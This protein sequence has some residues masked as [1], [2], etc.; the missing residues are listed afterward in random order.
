MRFFKNFSRYVLSVSLCMGIILSFSAGN[1]YAANDTVDSI[2]SSLLTVSVRTEK[3]YTDLPCTTVDTPEGEKKFYQFSLEGQTYTMKGTL[4]DGE[5]MVEGENQESAEFGLYGV[6][7]INNDSPAFNYKGSE[8]LS[9]NTKNMSGNIIG[10]GDDGG[11]AIFSAGALSFT[12]NGRLYV[13]GIRSDNTIIV[14]DGVIICNGEL[15]AKDGVFLI[16]GTV[17]AYGGDIQ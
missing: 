9:F 8:E 1:L 3:G 2:R 17:L 12:G 11:P 5:I 15:D 4:E 10:C 14:E 13:D 6:K 16:G 7:L